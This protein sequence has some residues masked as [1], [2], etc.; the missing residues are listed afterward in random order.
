MINPEHKLPITCQ[1]KFLEIAG[2]TVYC[3]PVRPPAHA[4]AIMAAFDRLHLEYPFAGF[5]MLRDMLRRSGFG[6]GRA[7]AG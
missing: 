4:L 3:P 2:F 6:G 7:G 1:A 5:R